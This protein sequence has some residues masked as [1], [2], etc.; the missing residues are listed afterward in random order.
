MLVVNGE[1]D[2]SLTIV[3]DLKGVFLDTH[4][5]GVAMFSHLYY[6]NSAS[7]MF[8]FDLNSGSGK[9]FIENDFG[10][11]HDG[12]LKLSKILKNSAEVY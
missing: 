4:W 5:F 1:I 3:A 6:W 11:A 8:W 12:S 9:T 10:N 2:P 7:G